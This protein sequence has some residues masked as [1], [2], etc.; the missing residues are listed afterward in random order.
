MI[1]NLQLLFENY[2]RCTLCPRKCGVNRSNGQTGYCG[3]TDQLRISSVGAHFGEEPPISGSNG[4]GTVFFSGCSLKCYY[5]QNYQISF[6]GL[7]SHFS[8]EQVADKI[9]ELV[10]SNNIHNVNFVTPDHFLPHTI[11]IVELLR[12]KNISLPILYNT[13]GYQK[14]AAVKALENYADIYL[15]DFKYAD[16]IL[17]KELSKAEDYPER[18][19][20]SLIEMVRQKGFMDSFTE[21]KTIATKGVMVRHLILP[22]QVQN[23]KDVLMTLFLE[24][25]KNIPISLMSQYYP[26]EDL[27]DSAAFGE[28]KFLNRN[29]TLPEFEEVY[30]H[31]LKLGLRNM[32]VQFPQDFRSK[33]DKTD[34]VPDF[35]KDKPFQR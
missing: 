29:I 5:C 32:F 30:E 20:N 26:P 2:Q 21:K 16:P 31:A 4:S 27:I 10:D 25:G 28:Y 11:R 33:K 8:C 22:D 35:I 12:E 18:A 1:N 24:F 6:A 19:L 23:S 17:A 3:E 13:S 9:K 7:G 34:F 15:P 14:L